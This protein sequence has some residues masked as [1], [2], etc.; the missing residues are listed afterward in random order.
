MKTTAPSSNGYEKLQ[1]TLEEI[2]EGKF[3][4]VSK[5]LLMEILST[6]FLYME[7]SKG[8]YDQIVNLMNK[9]FKELGCE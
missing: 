2:R 6:E 9:Y 3:S 8:G 4:D 5:N 1:S 7:D